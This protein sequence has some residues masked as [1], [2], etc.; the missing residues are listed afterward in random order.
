VEGEA[1]LATGSD[2]GFVLRVN[3][4]RVFEQDLDRAF[5]FDRDRVKV[6]LRKGENRLLLKLDPLSFI[7][8]SRREVACKES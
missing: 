4:Q 2:S 8:P 5:E 1:V 3:A 6:H 7:F